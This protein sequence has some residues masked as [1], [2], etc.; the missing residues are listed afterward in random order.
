M[1]DG[2]AP[3]TA[4]ELIAWVGCGSAPATID[5]NGRAVGLV[6]SSEN[7]TVAV[8]TVNVAELTFAG[9]EP[10]I[11]EVVEAAGAAVPTTVTMELVELELEEVTW[12]A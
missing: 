2:V 10:L 9:N 7:E 8:A 12:R 3:T 5:A 1:N 11:E 4:V 6:A